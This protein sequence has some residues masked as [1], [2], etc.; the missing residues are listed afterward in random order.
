M[1]RIPIAKKRGQGRSI[2]L[3][4]EMLVNMYAEAAPDDA[5][6]NLVVHG[7]P[8]ITQFS[9]L[10]ARARIRG[11][12]YMTA[13]EILWVVCGTTLFQVASNG[14]A[15]I[16][17]T[18]GGAGRVGMSD[19][20]FELIIT[21][22]GVSYS[23]N[24]RAPTLKPVVPTLTQITS[25]DFPDARTVSFM[26]GFFVFTNSREGSRGQFFISASYDGRVYD[27]SDFATAEQYPDNLVREFADHSQLILF[28]T[29]S[30]EFWFNSGAADF[31][32]APVQ[33]GVAE[34]GLGARWSVAKVDNSVIFLDRDGI[35][36]R[37]SGYTPTRISTHAIEFAI[38]KG[39]WRTDDENN[40]E[41]A[42]AFSY[43]EEGHEFYELSVPGAGTFVY[44][45][46]TD[47][48]HQR[49]SIGIDTRRVGFYTLAFN[50]H[51]VGD[52]ETGILHEQSLDVYQENDDP[53]IA[54]LQFPQVQNDGLRFI[55]HKFQ[56]DMEVGVG[57]GTADQVTPPPAPTPPPPTNLA[58]VVSGLGATAIVTLTAD[59]SPT[60]TNYVWRR[61]GAIIATTSNP[62]YVDTPGAAGTYSYTVAARNAIGDS[63]ESADVLAQIRASVPTVSATAVAKSATP[64]SEL[65]VS[66]PAEAQVGDWVYF[67]TASDGQNR[68]FTPS[69]GTN[70][71][72]VFN[73]NV[74]GS[75]RLQAWRRLVD[76]TELQ[77]YAFREGLSRTTSGMLAVLVVSGA[78]QAAASL[79]ALATTV[80]VSSGSGL[81]SP[82]LS[83][84]TEESLILHVGYCESG[85]GLSI[86]SVPAGT[87]QVLLED[88]SP[89][90]S[91]ATTVFLAIGSEILP[92]DG[93]T[94]SRE[95]SATGSGNAGSAAIAFENA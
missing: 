52:I 64:I 14:V 63:A 95:F 11:M 22:P 31:P 69:V 8:G 82:S 57:D 6:S 1:A 90:V 44:D 65:T 40:V 73:R 50:R 24:T 86:Q 92:A 59:S 7:T 49:K 53:L 47:L 88:N 66:I 62:T 36:R 5:K 60:A 78:N 18:I 9:T 71:V 93:S 74:A 10:D 17:G 91:P 80:A 35:V 3:S 37:F 55:V 26:D 41:G 34:K 21:S 75:G 25:S 12:H 46:A 67:I 77:E 19:N 51:I 42:T 72:S 58:A 68:F 29:D 85:Q 13:E 84:V 32:F 79:S 27:A 89:T 87:A 30:I 33:G 48:W 45:A 20:G 56:L 94:Q 16:R 81:T 39:A 83:A 54:E 38:S 28:G 70:L 76:G 61:D 43:I 23:Y 2:P 15:T 4:A